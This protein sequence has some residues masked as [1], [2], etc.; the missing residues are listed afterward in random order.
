MIDVTVDGDRVVASGDLRRVN[1]NWRL[2]RKILIQEGKYGGS[3]H[4]PG[5]CPVS[6]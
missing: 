3:F 2:E 1:G 5:G 4:R 6:G